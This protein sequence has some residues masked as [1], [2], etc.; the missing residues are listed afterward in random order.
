MKG[1]KEIYNQSE[2]VHSTNLELDPSFQHS[3]L[4]FSTDTHVASICKA[5]SKYYDFQQDG[6]VS[7][8]ELSRK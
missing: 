3:T 5:C 8:F 6:S 7:H 4:Y 2:V 1:I